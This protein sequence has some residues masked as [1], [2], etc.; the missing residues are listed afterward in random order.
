MAS[1]GA[2][3]PHSICRWGRDRR[4]IEFRDRILRNAEANLEAGMGSR[5]PFLRKM[6]CGIDAPDAESFRTTIPS[7]LKRLSTGN[8]FRIDL[9]EATPDS[10]E[11]FYRQVG[12]FNSSKAGSGYQAFPECLDPAGIGRYDLYIVVPCET[13]FIGDLKVTWPES[14]SAGPARVLGNYVAPLFQIFLTDFPEHNFNGVAALV[15]ETEHAL[16]DSLPYPCG[17]IMESSLEESETLAIL[18]SI[19]ELGDLHPF[20]VDGLYGG[21]GNP[22]VRATRSLRSAFEHFY[23]IS[24]L[25]LAFAVSCWC[26]RKDRVFSTSLPVDIPWSDLRAKARHYGTYRKED[27]Y[28]KVVKAATAEY[29]RRYAR[30]FRMPLSE[31]REIVSKIEL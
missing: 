8:A 12:A 18:K 21:I 23:G 9:L 20:L 16:H 1:A 3:I 13:S 28:Q 24:S 10:F 2:S 15:H 29:E 5:L 19:S 22:F 30:H 11:A 27:T 25:D 14:G 6:L 26:C 4:R 7:W 31:I 17:G